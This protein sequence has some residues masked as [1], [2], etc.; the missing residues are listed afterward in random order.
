MLFNCIYET[1]WFSFAL[2]KLLT[3]FT[4]M[5]AFITFKKKYVRYQMR[6]LGYGELDQM[7]FVNQLFQNNNF[8]VTIFGFEFADSRRLTMK[9]VQEFAQQMSKTFINFRCH[10]VTKHGTYYLKETETFNINQMVNY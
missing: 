3:A 5:L 2:K 4:V 7:S 6:Q 1:F 10:I 8:P 9:D